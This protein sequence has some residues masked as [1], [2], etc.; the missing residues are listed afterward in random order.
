MFRG[1]LRGR[2]VY[3]GVDHR[4]TVVQT[5][6]SA[7]P[8]WTVT[9]Y[10]YFI[11]LTRRTGDPLTPDSYREL[12]T[13]EPAD[14]W[15]FSHQ[16]APTSHHTTSLR[17]PHSKPR[18]CKGVSRCRTQQYAH[19]VES[20]E[21]ALLCATAAKMGIVAVVVTRSKSSHEL[22]CVF[23]I[24]AVSH[25]TPRS[26]SEPNCAPFTYHSPTHRRNQLLFRHIRNKPLPAHAAAECEAV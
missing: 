11:F 1:R 18:S 3:C 4:L 6:R 7:S 8:N 2:S 14:G 23:A 9:Q 17:S 22:K 20:L 12:A 19:I 25:S 13:K 15:I 26:T 5:A 16:L 21:D 10:R 24:Y